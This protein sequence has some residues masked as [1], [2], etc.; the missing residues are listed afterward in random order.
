MNDRTFSVIGFG[1]R[2]ESI[3]SQLNTEGIGVGWDRDTRLLMILVDNDESDDFVVR[4]CKKVK[5]KQCCIVFLCLSSELAF[6]ALQE[7]ADGILVNDNE[8]EVLSIVRTL[9]RVIYMYNLL[10]YDINDVIHFLRT[11]QVGTIRI[12]EH[13]F[14]GLLFS[15]VDKFEFPHNE[16]M[17]FRHL[18]FIN[19]C[20]Q[21]DESL[22]EEM[23]SVLNNYNEDFSLNSMVYDAEADCSTFVIISIT[24]TIQ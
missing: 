19:L 4:L 24:T 23:S 5:E 12:Q 20:Q 6:A 22:F 13:Q 11:K 2:C 7:V 8:Q 3:A 18:T 17:P 9:K 1:K 15:Q 14:P 16:K 10:S 21:P